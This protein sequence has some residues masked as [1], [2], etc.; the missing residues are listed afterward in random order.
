MPIPIQN[1]YYIFCYAWTNFPSGEMVEVGREKAPE[2]QNL[3]AMLL[4]N[5]FNRIARRGLARG[6]VPQQEDLNAPRGRLVLDQIIKRQTNLRSEVACQF[7]DLQ[8]DILKNQIIKAT[9]KVLHRSPNLEQTY[10]HGLGL[11]AR[12]LELVSDIR[13]S[14]NA[15][16]CV[17]IS[18]NDRS[19]GMLMKLCEFVFQ[20]ALPDEEG[21]GANFVDILENEA[22]MSTVFE[23]FLRNFYAHEQ[24]S[25]KVTRENYN[26]NAVSLTETGNNLLP[27]MQTD[28]ILRSDKRTVVADAKYYKETLKGR[29]HSAPKIN[30]SNLYQLF[31]YLH[32]AQIREPGKRIDG[33]LVY[34]SVGYG[35]REDYKIAGNN[36]RIA[37]IDLDQPWPEI[38]WDLLALL[39]DEYLC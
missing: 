2:L 35:V 17:Q 31:A 30:S 16:R 34:P 20:C 7:D 24:G 36:V 37:T 9:A 13:L 33:M 15:F 38:R 3:F 1:L 18:R 29:G 39:E 5:N 12:Q 11:L 19:Y 23:D 28:I 10:K 21:L 26:W 22:K 32:H 27:A 25:F 4:L 14:S 6:Y 8:S